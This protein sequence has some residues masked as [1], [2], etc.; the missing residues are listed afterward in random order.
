M[1]GKQYLRREEG[2]PPPPM[3]YSDVAAPGPTT[4][5]TGDKNL[6]HG[7]SDLANHLVT[8]SL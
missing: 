6:E 3:I 4:I 5:V 1:L 8:Y 2:S 7:L